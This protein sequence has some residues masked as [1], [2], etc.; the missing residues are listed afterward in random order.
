MSASKGSDDR[1]SGW[2]GAGKLLL[3]AEEA[4][5]FL[6][7]SRSEF[8]RWVVAGLC[9]RGVQVRNLRRWPVAELTRWVEA[10]CPTRAQWEAAR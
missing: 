3:R 10:G 5:Q 2:S 6:N 4:A 7:V 8:Y 9:P 1:A